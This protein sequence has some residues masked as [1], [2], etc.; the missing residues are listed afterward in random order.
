MGLSS[1]SSRNLLFPMKGLC[2]S[3]F[4]TLKDTISFYAFDISYKY[5]SWM[6][7]ELGV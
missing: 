7:V 1:L 4:E 6:T 3:Q 5:K 2:C